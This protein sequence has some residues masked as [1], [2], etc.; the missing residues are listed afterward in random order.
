MRIRNDML[1][2][3]YRIPLA[4]D[5]K[6]CWGWGSAAVPVMGRYKCY[7]ELPSAEYIRE[8]PSVR[9]SQSRL[10]A[11]KKQPPQVVTKASQTILDSLAN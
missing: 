9:L 4:G 3:K 7:G 6:L 11:T 10:D 8:M 5:D 1:N 2:L